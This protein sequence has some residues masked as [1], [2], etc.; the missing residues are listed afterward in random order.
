M[1]EI[2]HGDAYRRFREQYRRGEIAECRTC[3]WKR[4]YVPRGLAPEIL[5]SRGNH[6]QLLHGWHEPSGEN[7]IWGSQQAVAILAPRRGSRTLHVS[8]MLPQGPAGCPNELTI[9]VNGRE[10]GRVRNPWEETIPF[11]LDFA[12]PETEDSTWTIEFRT[13][14]RHV[15]EGEQRDLGFALVLLA[16]KQEVDVAAVRERRTAME[17]LAEWIRTVDRWAWRVRSRWRRPIPKAERGILSPGISIVVPE[18]ANP[19]ELAEC[20]AGV[21]QAAAKWKEPIEVIVVVNGS[22]AADY[23][24][25]RHAHPAVRWQFHARALGFGGAVR[26][27]LRDVHFPWVYLLNSDAVPEP[28]ALRELS[29]CRAQGTFSI[30][31]QIFLK[32]TTRFRDETN[33]TTL[34]VE[35]GLATVHDWLPRSESPVPGFYSGG[36]ASL[37]QARLLARLL[38]GGAYAPFYWEDVEWGWRARKLGYENVFC[39][40]SRVQHTQR[41]TIGKLYGSEEVERVVQRNRLLFQ[42]RNLTTAGSLEAV[43]DEM[44]QQD[45]S[46]DRGMR[47]QI[48]R[49]RVWNHLA[50]FSDE[51][52]LEGWAAHR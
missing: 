14:H 44:A 19:G 30:A 38:D 2:W 48:A 22:P 25:L 5:A 51:E 43:F 50:P 4:A 26:A 18:R 20:L 35:R 37:F 52:V 3:P 33:W 9:R 10:A 8:G 13:T 12:V 7:H 39:A 21:A 46:F 23:F 36:G 28:D 34:L 40:S 15:P 42:L 6:A 16:S 17:P 24:T 1:D 27:G 47:W 45:V 11:G 41:A 29:A 49:S 31:S 32:D